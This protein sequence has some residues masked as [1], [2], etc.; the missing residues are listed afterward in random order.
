VP[1]QQSAGEAAV[2]EDEPHPGPQAGVEQD[3]LGAVAVRHPGGQDHNGQQQAQ[4]VGDDEPLA[5]R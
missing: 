2:G 1:V 4:G 5:G 3:G